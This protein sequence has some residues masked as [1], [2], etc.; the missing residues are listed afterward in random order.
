MQVLQRLKRCRGDLADQS[1]LPEHRLHGLSLESCE[2]S[3]L[4]WAFRAAYQI[5][6]R[7]YKQAGKRNAIT[8]CKFS[9]RSRR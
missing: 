9:R 4:S 5:S 1:L 7:R 2:A 3:S 6:A 8:F